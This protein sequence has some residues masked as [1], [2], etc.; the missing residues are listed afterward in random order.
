MEFEVKLKF[1]RAKTVKRRLFNY[2][3]GNFDELR[4]FLKRNPIIINTT[5]SID[6]DWKQWK[7]TF[8][9]AV[10]RY[11]PMRTVK[12]TNSPPW[13]DNEVRRLIRKK[14]KAL[15]QYRINRSAARKRRLRSVTQ[16]IKY[17]IR[18]K[19]QGYLGKI[20][21]SLCD[22][23]KMFWSYHKSILHHRT[24]QGDVMTYNGVTAK[25]AKEKANIFNAY[26][27]SVIRSPSTPCK[28]MHRAESE[29]DISE[30]TLDVDE[31][32][33]FLRDLD[34]SKA[35]GPDG[36]PPRILQECALEI[37][38]SICELLNRSLHTGNVPSEWKS[39]NVTPVH[40]KDLKEPV[41][42]YRPISLLPIVGKV[43]ER[44]VCN[45]L[46]DHVKHLITKSQ[47]GFL[48]RKTCVTQLL[49]VLHIIGQ[50]LD[51]TIQTDVI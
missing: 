23:P 38:P 43:L 48:R 4:N 14:Y 41:E 45:R 21:C 17:L 8:L 34:T 1:K 24:G 36:I 32:G 39:A 19:H 7:D 37:A 29:G 20:E 44:C 22:N 9:T 35:C 28:N 18:S 31:V 13:N 16:Q 27:S 49:S 33:Q 25:T 26:F 5:D 15:N 51:K 11:I 30:V 47:H 40:K 12:H 42:H 10:R 2:G 6:D 46:Y 3:K 50:F